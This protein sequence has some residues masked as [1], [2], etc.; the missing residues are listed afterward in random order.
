VIDV[1]RI[2]KRILVALLSGALLAGCGEAGNSGTR[3][4]AAA[5]PP[6]GDWAGALERRL[7]EIDNDMP[8]RLGVHL[9]HADGT[10]IDRGAERDWYLA[11]TI[12]IPVAIAVLERVEAGELSLDETLTV[13]ETDFVDGAG[14]LHWRDPGFDI[15]L[16]ELIEKSLRDSDSTATD[17][18]IRL[19]GADHLNRRVAEWAGEGFND[20][21]TIMQVRYDVYG[22]AHPGVA[23]LSNMDIL[24]LRNAEAGEPR[25]QALARALGVPRD[26]LKGGDFDALFASYYETGLNSARLEAFGTLLERFYRGELLNEAHTSLLLKHM[27][28]ITTGDRRI[29]AGLPEDAAFA[30]KTGT[31]IGRACNVGILNPENADAALVVAAC[32]EDFGAM[33][34]AEQA[35]E[36]LGRAL[37]E[38]L[39]LR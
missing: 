30:Q 17:M 33:R 5:S 13:Q 20:I 29:A 25:L 14:D 18:L 3:T 28:A 4:A 2:G 10:R 9:R 23:E 36:A 16:E 22:P 26:E 11:S 39:G 19:V 31:Q 24:K 32:A 6:S 34:N 27:Q 1:A 7:E 35:F 15:R 37:G 21:T 8:G 12:K 38:S